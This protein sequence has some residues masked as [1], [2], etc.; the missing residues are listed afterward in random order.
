MNDRHPLGSA[1]DPDALRGSIFATHN[2]RFRQALTLRRAWSILLQREGSPDVM[3]EARHRRR[4]PE[5]WL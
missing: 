2:L 3:P 4:H 5:L 1:S